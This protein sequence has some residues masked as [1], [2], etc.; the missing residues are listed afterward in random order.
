MFDFFEILIPFLLIHIA[1]DFYLQPASWVAAKQARTWRAPALYCHALLHGVAMVI[2]ALLLGMSWQSTVCT[3]TMVALSHFFIDWWKVSAKHGARFSYFV[4]DQLLHIL[5]LVAL[6]YYFAHGVSVH[7][8]LTHPHFHHVLLIAFAYLLIL[9]PTSIV[10]AQVLKKYPIEQ[11]DDQS[12]V[13]SGL[14]AGGELIG[15]LERVLILTFTLVGSY[16]AVGFVLAAKSIF[17]FG[18]LSKSSGRNMTEYVLIGSLLS[19]VI[20]TLIGALTALGIGVELK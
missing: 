1:C 6:A 18:E 5:V 16:A 11:S 8:L 17:R 19:V 2:P 15:Y 20:T 4:G 7:T 14:V 10:I 9:K 13:A 3:V 12:S